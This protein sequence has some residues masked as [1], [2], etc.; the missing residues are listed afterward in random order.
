MIE[1]TEELRWLGL[2]LDPKLSFNIHIR[3][4]QQ[5]GKATI[6]QLHCIS[7]CYWGLSPQEIRSD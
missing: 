1:A 4:I 2:W 6:S 5:R 7:H 3:R